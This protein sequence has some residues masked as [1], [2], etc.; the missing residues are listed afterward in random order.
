[1][2]QATPECVDA[3]SRAPCDSISPRKANTGPKMPRHVDEQAIP[4]V[5]HLRVYFLAALRRL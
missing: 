3:E 1:M 4:S 5:H 2:R